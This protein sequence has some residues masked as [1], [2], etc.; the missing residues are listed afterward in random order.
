MNVATLSIN[1][2]VVDI[3]LEEVPL[4]HIQLLW[5]NLLKDALGTVHFVVVISLEVPLTLVQLLW[6]NLIMDTLRTTP[7]DTM[8]P[9]YN[10]LDVSVVTQKK[11]LISNVRIAISLS[12]S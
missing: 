3:S 5:V 9:T 8:W 2:V 1:F 6:V 11:A 10:L 4:T 7:L 12:L